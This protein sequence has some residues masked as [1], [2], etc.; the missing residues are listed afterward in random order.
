VD[1]DSG[2]AVPRLP[3]FI[4]RDIYSGGIG[5]GWSWFVQKENRE[6]QVVVGGACS[7][8]VVQWSGVCL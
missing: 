7:T 2:A 3:G 4:S 5:T 8:M 1:C 6:P